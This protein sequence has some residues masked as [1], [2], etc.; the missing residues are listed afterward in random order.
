MNDIIDES[1]W[2]AQARRGETMTRYALFYH[3]LFMPNNTW[4]WRFIPGVLVGFVGSLLLLGSRA[5]RKPTNQVR[6][7]AAMMPSWR[8]HRVAKKAG[9][10]HTRQRRFLF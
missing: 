3:P 8:N 9:T 5:R 10:R 1:R 2:G 6:L 4:V 7:D